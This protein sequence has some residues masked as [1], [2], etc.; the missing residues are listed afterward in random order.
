MIETINEKLAM[1]EY[2]N[3]LEPGL[4][5]S[6]G[7]IEQDDKQQF[8][9]DYPGILWGGKSLSPYIPTFRPRRR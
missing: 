1:L 6:P 8:L 3:I 2:C 7:T 4:P 5:M 9:W